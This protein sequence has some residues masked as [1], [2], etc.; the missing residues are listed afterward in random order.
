M[1]EPS[2]HLEIGA[3]AQGLDARI[4]F[5]WLPAVFAPWRDDQLSDICGSAVRLPARR[6]QTE[7]GVCSR[8]KPEPRKE[9]LVIIAWGRLPQ[10]RPIEAYGFVCE[11]PSA[12]HIEGLFE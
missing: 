11:T 7:L 9:T 5:V 4:G 12:D 2:E 10:L 6:K 8:P 3:F 1:R